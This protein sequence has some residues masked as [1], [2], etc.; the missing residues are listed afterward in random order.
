MGEEWEET[1]GAAERVNCK[2]AKHELQTLVC[3]ELRSL[4][5]G[6]AGLEEC[7]KNAPLLLGR[8]PARGKEKREPTVNNETLALQASPRDSPTAFR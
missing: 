4:I 1:M 3:L 6:R 5:G 2:H 8:S 7:M